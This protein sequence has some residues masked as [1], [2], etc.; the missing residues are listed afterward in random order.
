MSFSAAVLPKLSPLLPKSPLKD[1]QWQHI[2][3]LDLADPSFA[4]PAPV[5]CLIGADI[6][7]EI[8][9]DGLQRGPVGSPIAQNTI[10][11]WV[12]IGP[13]NSNSSRDVI[14][15]TVESYNTTIS[16]LDSLKDKLHKFWEIEELFNPPSLTPA[17]EECEAHFLSTHYRDESGRFVVRL[18]FKSEPHSPSQTKIAVAR[19]PIAKGFLAA[20]GLQSI[21]E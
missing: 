13:V 5:D 21:Y 2:K 20:R 16:P 15:R 9:R 11:S 14:L 8:V 12:L 19:A 4:T 17:E 10:F 18:P 7:S 6:Y 3:G 1:Y